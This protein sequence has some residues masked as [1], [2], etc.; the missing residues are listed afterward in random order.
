MF[1]CKVLSSR[2]SELASVHELEK[3]LFHIDPEFVEFCRE[4]LINLKR[5]DQIVPFPRCWILK[6]HTL[7]G[8]ITNL[9]G[10]KCGYGA[11]VHAIAKRTEE[12]E[13]N[14]EGQMD[15]GDERV[16]LCS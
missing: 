4:F 8:F 16:V 5:V 15:A 2:A 6:E 7:V 14:K 11:T 13:G 9:D 1:S 10:G 3:D 12:G